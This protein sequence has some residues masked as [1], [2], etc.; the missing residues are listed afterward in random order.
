M[1]QA[2]I[3]G[4]YCDIYYINGSF[5]WWY[6][7]ILSKNASVIGVIYTERTDPPLFK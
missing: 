5:L 2:L 1:L 4:V 3:T 6:N 7:L